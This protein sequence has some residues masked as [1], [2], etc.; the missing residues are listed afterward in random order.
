MDISVQFF[1]VPAL[2]RLSLFFLC[3]L[4]KKYR[5]IRGTLVC[6]STQYNLGNLYW[7]S[8]PITM[9]CFE[10]DWI[11][12][13]LVMRTSCALN[14]ETSLDLLPTLPYK[15]GTQKPINDLLKINFGIPPSQQGGYTKKTWCR[16]RPHFWYCYPVDCEE[17][18]DWLTGLK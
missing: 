7:R 3:Y 18:L 16:I 6:L 14:V 4:N 13:M 1:A 10:G 17:Q 5:S 15:T 9:T 2:M 12:E 8:G 11:V